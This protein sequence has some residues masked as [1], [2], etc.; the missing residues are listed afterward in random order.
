MKIKLLA[1]LLLSYVSITPTANAL[2]GSSLLEYC[3]DMAGRNFTFHA[4][5]C[6]STIDTTRK[7]LDKYQGDIIGRTNAVCL[8]D[9]VNSAVGLEQLVRV[10]L[11]Y[12]EDNPESLHIEAWGLV[13]V[14]LVEAFPCNE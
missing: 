14:A 13:V 12:L 7:M 4:G 10:V 6:V 8:P 2:T 3:K 5:S 1:L 11:K 9:E